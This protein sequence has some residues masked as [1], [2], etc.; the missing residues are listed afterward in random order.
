MLRALREYFLVTARVIRAMDMSFTKAFHE[1]V[2]EEGSREIEK[3]S[4]DNGSKALVSVH[5][6]NH[7]CSH[8]GRKGH[9]ADR[10]FH[11]PNSTCYRKSYIFKSD[12]G[13]KQHRKRHFSKNK[14][15]GNQSSD[16]GCDDFAN[17]ALLS[18]SVLR[19]DV[20]LPSTMK[21]KWFIGSTSTSTSH[22]CD[23]EDIF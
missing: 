13:Y 23:T 10:C 8:C 11:D 18:N 12:R 15:K 7:C 17:M 16:T 4:D 6:G 20:Q 22:I 21:A 19:D 2:F 9:T 14:K 3:L 1:L 5:C